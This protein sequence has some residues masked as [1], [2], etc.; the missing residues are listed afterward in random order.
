VKFLQAFG[1]KDHAGLLKSIQDIRVNTEMFYY[2]ICDDWINSIQD[3]YPLAYA[4]YKNQ[5]IYTI[6]AVT[7]SSVASSYTYTG[8]AIKPS[9][10]L[11]YGG[12]TKLTNGTDYT[13][14]FSDNTKVG[15]ATITI[16]GKGHYTGTTTVTFKI[17]PTKTTL[18]SVSNTKKK[19]MTV[20]WK[21]NLTGDGYEIQ[22]STKS[23]FSSGTKT[24][25][26]KKNAT[27]SKKI[28]G[29]TKNK[30]YYVRIRT[31]K[32]VSKKKYYSGWSS[33]KK[34]KISK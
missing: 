6:K 2:G 8:K 9:L 14:K 34:V 23:N 17:N 32:T 19:A 31:Y 20:K 18:S 5:L 27:T 26:V 12:D 33:V 16:T 13:V 24:A 10:S 29:L 1:A 25:T 3:S 21:K 15:T 4:V 7:V 11:N 30:T 22:Y 28:T